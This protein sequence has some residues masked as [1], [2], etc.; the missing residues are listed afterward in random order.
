MAN[1]VNVNEVKEI[2]NTSIDELNITAF[3]KAANLTVTELLGSDT[4]LSDDQLKEIE[5]FLAA[6]FIACT[7]ETN[8]LEFVWFEKTSSGFMHW[9][10]I[11]GVSKGMST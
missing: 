11:S 6:H 9:W 10:K 3:I 2:L 7:R 8:N 4:T 5:R 1:R